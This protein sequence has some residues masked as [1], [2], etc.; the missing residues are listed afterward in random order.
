M[1]PVL[2]SGGDTNPF[3]EA[4]SVGGL[5]HFSSSTATSTAPQMRIAYCSRN[6]ACG[7]RQFELFVQRGFKTFAVNEAHL[8]RSD[9]CEHAY[10]VFTQFLARG[11]PRATKVT[12]M[13]ALTTI[14][15]VAFLAAISIP[16]GA[17]GFTVTNNGGQASGRATTVTN[18][19]VQNKHKT[20][21]TVNLSGTGAGP[22]QAAESIPSVTLRY[23]RTVP[24]KT[25]SPY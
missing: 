1:S 5:F 6:A 9:R 4:A 14:L 24:A 8:S 19:S 12:I 7:R 11:S 13:K 15:A 22:A 10:P 20:H 2:G 25:P 3:E 17:D 18:T 23:Q 21:R 16:A